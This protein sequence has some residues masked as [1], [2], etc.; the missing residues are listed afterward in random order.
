MSMRRVAFDTETDIIA[1][2]RLAPRLACVT[3]FELGKMQRGRIL[4][5]QDG[6]ACIERGLAEREVVLVGH[7]VAYDLAVLLAAVDD[8][9][10]QLE[11]VRQVFAAYDDGRIACTQTREQLRKIALGRFKFDPLSGKPP[12]FTLAAL[13]LEYLGE[14]V[15]GKQGEDAWRFRYRE[16][17]GIPLEQ[18]PAEASEY[19]IYDAELTARVDARQ[20]ESCPFLGGV[21]PDEQ[22]QYR[23]AFALH[24]MSCWGFRTDPE[25]VERATY[26]YRRIYREK[27]SEL[28]QIGLVR[29]TGQKIQK[30]I[31]R[32]VDAAYGGNPPLTDHDDV[33]IERDVLEGSGDPGLILLA[34]R[35]KAETYL[36]RY[37]P[38][39]LEGT[40]CAITPRFDVLKETGRTS[41]AWQQMPKDDVAGI[42]ACIV[43]RPGCV[44]G[45]FDYSIA[46]LRAFAQVLLSFFGESRMAA[47][48]QA[49]RELHLAMAAGILSK[50]EGRAV[51]YDEVTARYKA[52]EDVAKKARDLAKAANFGFPGGLGAEAFIAFARSSYKIQLDRDPG[53]AMEAARGLKSDYLFEFPE[54]RQYFNLI[55]E[56][57]E[58][59]GGGMTVEHFK[60]GRLRGSTRYTAAC[61]SHFQGLVADFAKVGLY[62]VTKACFGVG[63]GGTDAPLYGCRPVLFVH[64]EIDL[65]A[66]EQRAPEAVDQMKEIA[67]AAGQEFCPDIPILGDVALV[68]RLSKSAKEVRDVSGRLQVWEPKA[69]VVEAVPAPAA[70]RASVLELVVVAAQL[71]EVGLEVRRQ[72]LA[73]PAPAG[74]GKPHERVA[75]YGAYLYLSEGEVAGCVEKAGGK[76]TAAKLP[77]IYEEL[78]VL[79]AQKITAIAVA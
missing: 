31:K 51:T 18:W 6:L 77:R 46:E 3:I 79:A 54:V 70:V 33:S 22:P 50:S 25:Q 39:L 74:T 8:P 42:R 61:N 12:T 16:L 48:L 32:R 41:S 11:L 7:N 15:Q 19:A 1:P 23:A 58:A 55:G 71:V 62:R 68:R 44:F 13:A 66:P 75:Q 47:E 9:V 57:C 53:K 52:G 64:D 30:E 43:P 36:S 76:P 35:G 24:L 17:I 63:E 59:G 29:P 34:E 5:V 73:T 26:R 2:G 21:Y 78:R 60:S 27:T 38:W 67:I 65:E 14:H 69:K 37:L 45:I 40:R 4:D 49:G 56:H 20:T 28:A 72:R 10:R